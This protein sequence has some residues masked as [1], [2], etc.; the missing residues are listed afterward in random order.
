MFWGYMTPDLLETQAHL[1]PP[2]HGH[3]PHIGVLEAKIYVM[4][5][6]LNGS[7][8]DNSGKSDKAMRV[9]SC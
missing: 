3:W 5:L 8:V 6:I 7:P 4:P 1:D 2:L 9:N